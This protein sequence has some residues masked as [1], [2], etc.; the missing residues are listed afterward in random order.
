MWLVVMSKF[1]RG[2][3]IL[4]GGMLS[5]VCRF[6]WYYWAALF[7]TNCRYSKLSLLRI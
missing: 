2:L 4:G 5:T 6:G 7:L 3:L 1:K